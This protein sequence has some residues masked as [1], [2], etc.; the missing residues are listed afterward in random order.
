MLM[1]SNSANLAVFATISSPSLTRA[2]DRS[3]AV[4]LIN[5]Q[6]Q[7]LFLLKVDFRTILCEPLL[8]C[9]LGILHSSVDILLASFG[10]LNGWLLGGRVDELE[11]L[12]RFGRDKL[13][14]QYQQSIFVFSSSAFNV[15]RC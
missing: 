3:L 12:A 4:K 6:H 14:L 10:D 11:C 13:D 9:T 2:A 1:A 7:C 15:P 8:P 5:R